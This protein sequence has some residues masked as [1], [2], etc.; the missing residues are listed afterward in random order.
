MIRCQECGFTN[1]PGAAV[2]KKCGSRLENS[3]AGAPEPKG[4][5][6]GGNPTMIGGAASAPAWDS[7]KSAP[8]PPPSSGGRLS[9][10]TII[11]NRS[12]MPAW[13]EGNTGPSAPASGG[14]NAPS[15]PTVVSGGGGA[16]VT[17]NVAKCPSCGFYPLRADVS[18]SHPCPNCG[19]TGSGPS[20]DVKPP[21]AYTPAA[22]AQQ[23]P[24]ASHQ[25]Q[26]ASGAQKTMRLGD[27]TPAE[28]EKPEFRLVD[29]RSQ[30]GKEFMGEEVSVNRDNL[31]AGNMSISGTEHAKFVFEDGK[32]FLTDHS[33]NGATFLQVSGKVELTD[34]AKIL[35]G[36]RIYTFESK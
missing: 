4:N 12:N 16:A 17:G 7:G 33:S 1:E 14:V 13:D 32:W 2:C 22:K 30:N 26:K 5:A 19:A 3:E 25:M 6:G 31:D 9:N 35:I 18:A 28:D 11:G 8:T 29:E 34:G 15:N 21:E 23:Q 36:N 20:A 10:P 27:L 24:D